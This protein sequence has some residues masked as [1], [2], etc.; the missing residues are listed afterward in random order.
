MVFGMC[1]T[2]V[3]TFIVTFAKDAVEVRSQRQAVPVT[4]GSKIE[5]VTSDESKKTL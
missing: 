2:R 4:A 1:A 5:E 3:I